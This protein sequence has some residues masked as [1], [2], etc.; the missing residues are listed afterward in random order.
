MH[1]FKLGLIL[2]FLLINV[3]LYVGLLNILN[4]L[5]KTNIKRTFEGLKVAVSQ[6]RKEVPNLDRS[7]T[8]LDLNKYNIKQKPSIKEFADDCVNKGP[9]NIATLFVTGSP[10]NYIAYYS[11]N[12]VDLNL[13]P[14]RDSQPVPTDPSPVPTDTSPVPADPQ[15][16]PLETRLGVF[17]VVKGEE[18]GRPA[19]RQSR[20]RR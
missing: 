1:I 4:A 15:P 13:P 8:F 11:T 2:F 3:T 12:K 5:R 10:P 6:G 14:A 19:R 16:V 17:P 9:D 18:R 20:R 7:Y